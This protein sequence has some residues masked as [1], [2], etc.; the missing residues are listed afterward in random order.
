MVVIVPD[1]N[2][3][4]RLISELRSYEINFVAEKKCGQW[5]ITI[6]K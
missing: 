6:V 4:T 5:E 2:T 1:I 3:L